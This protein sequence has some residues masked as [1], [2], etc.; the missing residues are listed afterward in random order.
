MQKVDSL[1]RT[2]SKERTLLQELKCSSMTSW[3]IQHHVSMPLIYSIMGRWS[4]INYFQ[5]PPTSTRLHSRHNTAIPMISISP[6]PLPSSPPLPPLLPPF[7]P[8]SRPPGEGC[9]WEG[10]VL[11]P[12]LSREGV[13]WRSHTQHCGCGYARL[14]KVR[15]LERTVS[16]L[17]SNLTVEGRR[18]DA[19][20]EQLQE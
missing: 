13:I 17:K 20:R 2:L 4:I 14:E 15:E 9:S 1:E 18:C 7:L 6:L 3:L 12:W 5:A 11:P 10:E 8:S 16:S 19:L